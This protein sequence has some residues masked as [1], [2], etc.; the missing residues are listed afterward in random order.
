MVMVVM[1]VRLAFGGMV[2]PIEERVAIDVR[3]IQQFP[4]DQ[5]H[6][7]QACQKIEWT[8]HEE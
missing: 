7:H 5:Q 4:N 2:Q 1:M 6:N 3:R 8:H